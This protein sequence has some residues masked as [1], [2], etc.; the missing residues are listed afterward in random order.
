MPDIDYELPRAES[1]S[2]EE[3]GR[4]HERPQE[5]LEPNRQ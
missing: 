3:F 1:R 2:R 4:V 5:A